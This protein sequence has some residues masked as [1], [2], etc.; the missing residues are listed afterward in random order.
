MPC[1]YDID[2]CERCLQEFKDES[3][4]CFVRADVGAQP[5]GEA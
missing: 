3:L 1:L 5:S 2:D 4:Y